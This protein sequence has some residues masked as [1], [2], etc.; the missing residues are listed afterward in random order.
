MISLPILL[1]LVTAVL[2]GTGMRLA[3]RLAPVTA[4]LPLALALLPEQSLLLPPVLLGLE[5]AIDAGNRPLLILVGIVWPLAAWYG[6]GHVKPDIRRFWT[7]W[8]VTLAGVLLALMA[9]DI[10]GFYAGYAATTLAA[11]GLIAHAGTPESRRAARIYLVMAI[12][13]E[14]LI[15]Y[16]LMTLALDGAAAPPVMWLLFAGF[17]V[18]AGIVPLHVWLPLAH[19]IAPAPASAVLSGVIVNIGLLG[20]L[21]FVTPD[22]LPAADA[23][24]PWLVALGLV[25][26]FYAALAGLKQRKLKSVL[27]YSTVSQMGL[28]LIGFAM[29]LGGGSALPVLL[30]ALHHGLNKAALFVGAGLGSGRNPLRLALMALPAAA[31]AGWPFTGGYL[32]KGTLKLQMYEA[33]LG[34]WP[35]IVVALTA[36]TT[37]LLM[38][39]VLW[40]ARR[41]ESVAPMHAAWPLLVTAGA[42][43][44]WIVRGMLQEPGD[45]DLLQSVWPIAV[46]ILLAAAFLYSGKALMPG[47][48]L[49][50][51]DVL[52]LIPRVS[53]PSWRLRWVSHETR[54]ALR[55]RLFQAAAR[56]IGRA[57]NWLSGMPGTGLALLLVSAALWWQM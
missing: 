32:A 18:K 4:L 16:A 49:P 12:S 29:T 51:G 56:F 48:Y 1:A 52:A 15:L 57:E 43:V 3:P 40:L 7:W 41:Q 31:L 47:R 28:V 22:A 36:V 20:W 34:G 44:P 37:T 35:V 27:A 53:R 10:A 9:T 38:A 55:H 14:L 21:R 19:S 11:F 46:G 33:G 24:V 8:N 54:A 42:L 50:E 30:F 2:C 6:L 45:P 17:A 39:R 26:C 23:A 25:T 13:A 5:L